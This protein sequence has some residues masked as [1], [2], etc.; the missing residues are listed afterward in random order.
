MEGW[1]P[2]ET[3]PRDG[4]PFQAK[5][6]GYGSDNIIAYYDGFLDEDENPCGGWAFVEEQE[7]PDCWTDGVCWAKNDAGKPSIKPTHWMPLP[8]PPKDAA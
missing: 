2:I 6:P 4:T 3:A 8:E 1:Q 5:I 7:V